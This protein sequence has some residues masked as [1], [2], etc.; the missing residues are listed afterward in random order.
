MTRLDW[1]A[2][3]LTDA[4]LTVQPFAGWETRGRSTRYDP[5]I[6]VDHH[7]AGPLRGSAPSLGVCVNGRPDVPGPLCNLLTGRDGVVHVIAAGRSNNAGPGGAP[8]WG[9]T[10]NR[11]TIGHE[12][13]HTGNLATEPLNG[14]QLETIAAVDAV[15]CARLGWEAGRCIGHREWAPGRKIDPVWSQTAHRARVAALIGEQ[16]VSKTVREQAG[17]AAMFDRYRWF[18][19]DMAPHRQAPSADAETFWR[20]KIAEAVERDV[21]QLGTPNLDAVIS[22]LTERLRDERSDRE[23]ERLTQ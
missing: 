3:A 15:I 9:A 20:A 14:R 11:H 19:S 18:R 6:I 8:Q 23:T 10:H 4:G 21:G 2:D 22:D 7:T 17:I 1:L 5:R 12:V 13:E 16:H